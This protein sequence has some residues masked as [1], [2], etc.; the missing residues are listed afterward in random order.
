[1]HAQSRVRI[2][3]SVVFAWPR[4]KE[5]VTLQARMSLRSFPT[6]PNDKT[7]PY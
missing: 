6:L 4:Q 2:L 7:N 3:K 5:F 1:M